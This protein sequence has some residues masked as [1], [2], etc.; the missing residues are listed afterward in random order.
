[1]MEVY[2]RADPRELAKSGEQFASRMYSGISIVLPFCSGY[3]IAV[4][5]QPQHKG[6]RGEFFDP[7]ILRAAQ[8]TQLH[9]RMS[10]VMAESGVPWENEDMTWCCPD[11]FILFSLNVFKVRNDK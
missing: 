5:Q 3:C 2:L 9:R 1:M 11:C 10:W 7:E 6:V 4:L 8:S